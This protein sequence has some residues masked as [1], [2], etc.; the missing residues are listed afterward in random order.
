[1]ENLRILQEI[2]KNGLVV[3]LLFMATNGCAKRFPYQVSAPAQ[4]KST[5]PSAATK[6]FVSGT[7][8]GTDGK[9]VNL[10]D[11]TSQ[12]IVVIFAQDTCTTCLAE[13]EEF[14]DSLSERTHE[15][16][17]VKVVSI[18]VGAA[19]DDAIDWKNLHSVPWTVTVDTGDPLFRSYCADGKVPCTVVQLP[20]QGIVFKRVGA[21]SL[22]EITKLTGNWEK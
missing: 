19:L 18:L 3:S 16:A 22:A 17:K 5:A 14:R 8:I 13:T 20:E 10:S 21:S 2:L 15:P 9:P 11:Y 4:K 12:P 7:V 6:K 1:M